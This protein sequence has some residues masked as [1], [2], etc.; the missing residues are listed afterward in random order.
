VHP[1]LYSR[2]SQKPGLARRLFSFGNKGFDGDH[3]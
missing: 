3:P 1:N 2:P